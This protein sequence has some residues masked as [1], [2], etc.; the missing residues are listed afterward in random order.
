MLWSTVSMPYFLSPRL[1]DEQNPQPGR[2]YSSTTGAADPGPA[3]CEISPIDTV[4]PATPSPVTGDEPH[5][6]PSSSGMGE[7]I[8]QGGVWSGVESAW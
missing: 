7:P 1:S 4:W 2:Q 8:A 5:N 6:Q 3:G